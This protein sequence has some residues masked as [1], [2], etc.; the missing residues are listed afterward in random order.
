MHEDHEGAMQVRRPLV[1][2]ARAHEVVYIN[3]NRPECRP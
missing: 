1:S 3:L 2:V